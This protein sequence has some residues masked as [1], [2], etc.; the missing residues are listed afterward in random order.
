[1]TSASAPPVPIP[2]QV[3]WRDDADTTVQLFVRDLVLAA[4][5][6]I[7]PHEHNRRQRV[8]LNLDLTVQDWAAGPPLVPEQIDEVVSYET[9]VEA[10]RRL[11]A[12]RHWPLVE[13]LAERLAA[14]ALADRRVLSVRVRVEKLDAFAEAAAVGVEIVRHR[15]PV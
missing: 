12:E 2:P 7:H 4:A 15:P 5:I 13:T 10:A 1:M 14:A 9:L 11:V 3:S 6:G 8:R